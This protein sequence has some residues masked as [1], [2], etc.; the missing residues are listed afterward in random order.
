MKAKAIQIGVIFTIFIFFIIVAKT[1]ES[2]IKNKKS[3]VQIEL[4]KFIPEQDTFYRKWIWS[5]K[6]NLYFSYND[7]IS[8]DARL[9]M[10]KGYEINPEQLVYL[11]RLVYFEGGFD[12]R[13]KNNESKLK[14]GMIA[15][16]HVLI[17]RLN[18]DLKN[19]LENKEPKFSNKSVNL[20]NIGFKKWKNRFNSYTYEFTCTLNEKEYFLPHLGNEKFD[21][22]KDDKLNLIVGDMDSSRA[23]L[24]YDCLIGSLRDIYPDPTNGALFYQN[25]R[26][27]DKFNKN[28]KKTKKHITKINSHDFYAMK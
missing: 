21:L 3:N 27:S 4:I 8:W 2:P 13:A 20:Y 26:M 14:K 17:N 15:I 28:W 7:R 23:L 11:S 6:E 16:S 10:L 24:A 5:E 1:Y 9:L 19:I 25:I 22:Y 18:Y 12:L